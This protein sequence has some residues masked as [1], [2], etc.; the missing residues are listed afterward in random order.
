ME[1]PNDEGTHAARGIGHNVLCPLCGYPRLPIPK[2][3]S[4]IIPLTVCGP[5]HQHHVALQVKS[6]TQRRGVRFSHYEVFHR[7]LH[8]ALGRLLLHYVNY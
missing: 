8:S 6:Y 7:V 4:D 5:H 2:I 3:R 1:Y